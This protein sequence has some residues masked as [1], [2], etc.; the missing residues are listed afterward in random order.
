MM[1]ASERRRWSP[2]GFGLA[3]F[4]L[5]TGLICGPPAVAGQGPSVNLG[6]MSLEELLTIRVVSAGKRGQLITETATAIYVITAD[7]IRRQ[8]THPR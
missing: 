4:A 6:D 3:G 7:D 2:A 5:T 8:R 1:S